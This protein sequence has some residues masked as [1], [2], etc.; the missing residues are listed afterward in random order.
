MWF[1][2]GRTGWFGSE[3]GQHVVRTL[4]AAWKRLTKPRADLEKLAR[5]CTI[6]IGARAILDLSVRA[7]D[8]D[9]AL[10]AFLDAR[11]GDT[12]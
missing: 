6:I 11:L 10:R 8:A 7:A 12:L 5:L 1:Y 3:G 9:P 2:E 4:Y